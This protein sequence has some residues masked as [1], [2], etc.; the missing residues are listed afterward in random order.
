[1]ICP[2]HSCAPAALI[3]DQALFCQMLHKYEIKNSLY[4]QELA[5]SSQKMIAGCTL[6]L[7]WQCSHLSMSWPGR[8]SCETERWVFSTTWFPQNPKFKT[9]VTYMALVL[10]SLLQLKGWPV[11]SGTFPPLLKDRYFLVVDKKK[12]FWIPVYVLV[13]HLKCLFWRRA[14]CSFIKPAKRGSTVTS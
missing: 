9:P 4:Q 13:N 6:Q 2:P 8:S 14:S 5:L 1:M 10:G 7:N 11:V 3:G 12:K